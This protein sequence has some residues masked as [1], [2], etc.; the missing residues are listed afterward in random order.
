MK[1]NKKNERNKDNGDKPSR[2]D[3]IT[4]IRMSPGD[5]GVVS[6][7][8]ATGVMVIVPYNETDSDWTDFIKMEVPTHCGSGKYII[9]VPVG[10]YTQRGAIL[11]MP[12]HVAYRFA[13]I[14]LRAG[15][16]RL[17]D[18]DTYV[19]PTREQEEALERKKK[20]IPDFYEYDSD[21]AGTDHSYKNSTRNRRRVPRQS[22]GRHKGQPVPCYTPKNYSAEFLFKM[23]LPMLRII[24]P[25]SNEMGVKIVGEATQHQQ[26]RVNVR[27][28]LYVPTPKEEEE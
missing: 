3:P 4:S 17:L 16:N 1:E 5:S 13:E 26:T 6:G 14:G 10:R 8:I 28:V 21:F 25:D 22:S 11:S 15:T 2:R 24:P 19:Y 9:K 27:R 23:L 12:A 7:I 20:T 18:P